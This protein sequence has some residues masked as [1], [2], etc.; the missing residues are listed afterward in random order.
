MWRTVCPPSLLW[1][2][3]VRRSSML[4]MSKLSSV[5]KPSVEV[6]SAAASTQL[7][8]ECHEGGVLYRERRPIGI[9]N[10]GAVEAEP[11]NYPTVFVAATFRCSRVAGVALNYVR[12]RPSYQSTTELPL[13]RG[14]FWSSGKRW[15]AIYFVPVPGRRR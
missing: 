2:R 15:S 14:H 6:P 7:A 1:C 5:F 8:L 10:V 3:A 9:S 13:W 11:S 12:R 4:I